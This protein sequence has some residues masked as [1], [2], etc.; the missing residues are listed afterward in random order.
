MSTN[1]FL[2]A[3]F[4]FSKIIIVA[5]RLHHHCYHPVIILIIMR[6][7]SCETDTSILVYWYKSY[8]LVDHHCHQNCMDEK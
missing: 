5:K 7:T 6:I 3:S 8:L 2:L 4:I 1:A